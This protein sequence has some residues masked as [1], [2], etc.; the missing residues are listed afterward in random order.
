M[1]SDL[2]TIIIL[3]GSIAFHSIIQVAIFSMLHSFL[4]EITGLVAITSSPFVRLSKTRRAVE[5]NATYEYNAFSTF[6]A[7]SRP[8]LEEVT[9]GYP[10]LRN[11][12]LGR[13]VGSSVILV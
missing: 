4:F 6:I 8:V 7:L 13:K 10:S 5:Y 3:D 1:F 9:R 12:N 11:Y 2:S